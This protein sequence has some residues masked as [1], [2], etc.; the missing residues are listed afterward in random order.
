MI[1]A[2]SQKVNEVKRSKIVWV[3][4]IIGLVVLI[5]LGGVYKNSRDTKKS[6]ISNRIVAT[7]YCNLQNPLDHNFAKLV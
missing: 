4:S 2:E 5:I 3:F 7:K 6:I 1:E